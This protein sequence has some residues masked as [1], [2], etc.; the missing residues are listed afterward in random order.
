MNICFASSF[1]RFYL[2][3]NGFC[4]LEKKKLRRTSILS[5]LKES[6]YTMYLVITHFLAELVLEISTILY[7]EP[8]C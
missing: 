1:Q 2:A 7:F 6:H 4:K 3:V 8:Y 5:W